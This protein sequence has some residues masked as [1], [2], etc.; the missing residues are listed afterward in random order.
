M[1]LKISPVILISLLLMACKSKEQKISPAEEKITESVYAAG[2]LKTTNQYDVYAS[3]NGVLKEVLVT[4]GD[5][6]KKGSP[7]FRITNTQSQLNTENAQI[8]AEAA[9]LSANAARLK[10]LQN[11]TVLAKAKMENEASLL[12]RQ[13]N[14]WNQQIGTRNEVDSREVAYKTAATAYEAAKL[15]LA[16]LQQQ[17]RYQ[18]MQANKAVEISQSNTADYTVKSSTDGIVYTVLKEKGEMVTPQ[19]PLAVVGDSA[20]FILELQVDEYDIARVK[21]GQ[22]IAVNMDSYKGT[23][24]EAVVVKI[25]PLMNERSK[26]FTVEAAFVQRPPVLYPNLTCEAN[27]IIQDKPKAL[28]IPRTFLLDGDTVLLAGGEKRKVIT[29]LKDYQKAEIISGITASDIL[30]KPVQ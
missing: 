9:S 19:S 13:R 4:E 24:F 5:R 27:I 17:L 3:V 6:V 28:T 2:V 15:A 7:L 1:L 18:S 16:Q 21:A 14:L 8:A 29:G 30:I 25:N 11:N 23:V 20:A 26:S 12:Q 10:E 22:K